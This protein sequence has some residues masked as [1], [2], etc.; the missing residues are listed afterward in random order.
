M[1]LEPKAAGKKTGVQTWRSWLEPR[2]FRGTDSFLYA[3]VGRLFRRVLCT[4]DQSLDPAVHTRSAVHTVRSRIIFT[5]AD[6]FWDSRTVTKVEAPNIFCSQTYAPTRR[7]FRI[8]LG[9]KHSRRSSAACAPPD[10]VVQRGPRSLT[11][12]SLL[13]TGAHRFVCRKP[14]PHGSAARAATGLDGCGTSCSRVTS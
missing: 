6:H 7:S 9:E 1:A 12:S 10:Q 13:L 4:P 11:S 2:L 14:A 8:K 3:V 5:P